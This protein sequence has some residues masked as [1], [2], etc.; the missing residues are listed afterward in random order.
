M[1]VHGKA[2]E[3]MAEP[4]RNGRGVDQRAKR[5]GV[6]YTVEEKK[7]GTSEVSFVKE[8]GKEK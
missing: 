2:M 3:A 1:L 8:N 4:I 6:V 7:E 5:R